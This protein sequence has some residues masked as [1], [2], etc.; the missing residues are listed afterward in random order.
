MGVAGGLR[1]ELRFAGTAWVDFARLAGVVAVTRACFAQIRITEI[2]DRA[3]I[4]VTVAAL[5]AG[6][7]IARVVEYEIDDVPAVGVAGGIRSTWCIG[8]AII[9]GRGAAHETVAADHL[10][11]QL[12]RRKGVPGGVVE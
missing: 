7:R 10:E 5:G 4:G 11:P 12:W 6:N 3:G 9:L 2:A 8:L 1:G